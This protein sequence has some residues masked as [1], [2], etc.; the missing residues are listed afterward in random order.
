MRRFTWNL[1]SQNAEVIGV[2][3]DTLTVGFEN[4]GARDRSSAR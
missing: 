2:D 3:A 4:A 1:L